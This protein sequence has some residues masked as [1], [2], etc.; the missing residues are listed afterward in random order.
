[1]LR[2]QLGEK[3]AKAAGVDFA[4]PIVVRKAEAEAEPAPKQRTERRGER[5]EGKKPEKR[6]ARSHEKRLPGRPLR[7]E[8]RRDTYDARDEAPARRGPRGAAAGRRGRDNKR[9]R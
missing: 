1:M 7:G 2:D 9:G 3:L 8:G 4:A 5:R 6:G